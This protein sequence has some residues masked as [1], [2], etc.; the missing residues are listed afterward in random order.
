MAAINKDKEVALTQ[1]LLKGRL[2]YDKDTGIFTWLDVK[3]NP[4]RMRG[5]VAGCLLTTGY[6]QIELRVNDKRCTYRAHRLAWLYEYGEFPKGNLDHINHV[7]TDN[8]I[9][10]LRIVTQAENLRNMSMSSRNTTGYT[11]VHFHKVT[12]KYCAS[13]RV[14][15][16]QISLGYFEN[17][18]DAAKAAREGRAH[19]GFHVNH[20]QAND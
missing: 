13:V 2:H 7:K 15:Y 12:G 3:G 4:H 1:E 19:Y 18:E 5:K 11:G 16:K 20:G 10:N 6:V 9:T 17:I 14:S 8:R